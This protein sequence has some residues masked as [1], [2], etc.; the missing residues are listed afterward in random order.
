MSDRNRVRIHE[1]G[2]AVAIHAYGQESGAVVRFGRHEGHTHHWTPSDRAMERMTTDEIRA[3]READIVISLAGEAALEVFGDPN[4]SGGAQGDRENALE[5]ARLL[6]AA[7]IASAATLAIVARLYVRALALAREHRAA[8]ERLAETLALNGDRLAGHQVRA[9]LLAAFG[10]WPTQRFDPKSEDRVLTRTR[11]LFELHV[12]ET[13]SAVERIVLMR[14]SEAA[15]R[16]GLDLAQ[17]RR[18]GLYGPDITPVP[19]KGA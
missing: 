12:R 15:A 6:D 13:D 2:H 9:A 14:D 19:L 5:T 3:L 16:A 7:P 17:Y 1:A 4:P 10:G 8:I 18:E 11:H